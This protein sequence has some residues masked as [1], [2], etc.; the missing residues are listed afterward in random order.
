MQPTTMCRSRQARTALLLTAAVLHPV[1]VVYLDQAGS[2]GPGSAFARTPD[3]AGRGLNENLAREVLE[4][5]TLGVGG[6]YVQRDVRQ[7]AE[8]LAG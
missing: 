7:L 2:V 8:L 4:L 5:H 6:D 1:M 3:R